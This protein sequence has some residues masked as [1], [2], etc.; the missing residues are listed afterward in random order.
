MNMDSQEDVYGKIFSDLLNKYWQ[1]PDHLIEVMLE[2]E[3]YEVKQL[4]EKLDD[5]RVEIY[6]NDHHP[7]HFHVTNKEKTINARFKIEN[8]EHINGELTS[9]QLK[10][11]RVFYESTKVKPYMEKLWNKR[12]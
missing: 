2:I 10:R 3:G 1:Y 5:L 9:K 4:V 6:S 8:G 11:I 12:N 7:P